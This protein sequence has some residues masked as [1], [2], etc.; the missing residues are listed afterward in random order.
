MAALP[1]LKRKLLHSISL[2]RSVGYLNQ[3][4][5]GKIYVAGVRYIDLVSHN[6]IAIVYIYVNE[7]VID[8]S[9][10]IKAPDFGDKSGVQPSVKAYGFIN[11]FV[12]KRQIE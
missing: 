1:L 8:I 9:G 5:K 11:P 12:R 6:V 4:L 10:L 7:K 2:V 3:L